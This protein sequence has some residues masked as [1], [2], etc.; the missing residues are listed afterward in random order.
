MNYQ[1]IRNWKFKRVYR[2]WSNREIYYSYFT[3][4]AESEFHNPGVLLLKWKFHFR[5]YKVL[6]HRFRHIEKVKFQKQLVDED[7]FILVFQKFM[8]NRPSKTAPNSIFFSFFRCIT[9]LSF[10]VLESVGR[11]YFAKDL[12]LTEYV[13]HFPCGIMLSLSA[14]SFK[15]P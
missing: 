15:G 12:S 4:Y 8:W 14:P 2:F 3:T 1:A 13:L 10:R 7:I 5:F 6:F 11:A 9:H